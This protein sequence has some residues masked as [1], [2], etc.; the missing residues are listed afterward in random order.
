M[1]T[2]GLLVLSAGVTI[3]PPTWLAGQA[4]SYSTGSH[5]WPCQPTT[6]TGRWPVSRAVADTYGTAV[7]HHQ[8]S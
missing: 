4:R 8:L 6:F 1:Q 7:V 2:G 3:W 5:L